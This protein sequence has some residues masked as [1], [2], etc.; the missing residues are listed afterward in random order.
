MKYDVQLHAIVRVKV[1]DVSA[2][3]QRA[4]AQRALRRVDLN[5]LFN[6]CAPHSNVAH[7][8]FDDEV[9]H[10]VLERSG[11]ETGKEP[12]TSKCF[13]PFGS[14]GLTEVPFDRVSTHVAVI[15]EDGNVQSLVTNRPCQVA[16]L[17]YD[18]AQK[19]D[20]DV[21]EETE[22][23]DSE[24]DPWFRC[25]HIFQTRHTKEKAT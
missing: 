3:N 7:T 11:N 2:P 9:T 6:K 15:V 14:G 18:H 19:S 25:H 24:V 5:A 23:H 22:F 4:A 8:E 16:V 20:Y 1:V 17:N 12:A 21:E 13:E 10:L